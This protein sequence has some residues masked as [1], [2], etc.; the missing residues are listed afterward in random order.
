ML[1]YNFAKYA[2]INEST[3]RRIEWKKHIKKQK[4]IEANLN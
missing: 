1:E 3:S 4:I 2:K